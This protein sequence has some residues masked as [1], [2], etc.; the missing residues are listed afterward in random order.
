MAEIKT[1]EE[2]D[3]FLSKN[4]IIYDYG[5]GAMGLGIYIYNEILNIITFIKDTENATRD[6]K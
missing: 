3:W 4:R 1:K 5:F 2:P 6:K